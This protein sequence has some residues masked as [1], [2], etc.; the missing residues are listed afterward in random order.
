MRKLILVG[1]I[2]TIACTQRVNAQDKINM[3]VKKEVVIL[4]STQSYQAALQTARQAASRLHIP[5]DLEGYRPH[6]SAGLTLS[7]AACA[8]NGFEYP[9]YI[10]RGY[11]LVADSAFVSV[12]YSNGYEGFTKGYYL[13]VAAV[14]QPSAAAVR[15]T[16]VTSQR[17]YA[18]AYTKRT[19]VY[20]GCMH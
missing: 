15:Q 20:I 7:K 12:E 19:T 13:V 1:L 8:N 5:L 17:Y 6:P 2:T 11:G 3:L 18:D 9:T 16:S 10:P 4:Q 14:G